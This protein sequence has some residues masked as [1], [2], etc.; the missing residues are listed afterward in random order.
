LPPSIPLQEADGNHIILNLGHGRFALYA[1]LRAASRYTT[2]TGF[3][4]G[5]PSPVSATRG[6]PRHPTC[7]SM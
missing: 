5:K 6:T 7:T 4:G 1:H 2:E 3:G